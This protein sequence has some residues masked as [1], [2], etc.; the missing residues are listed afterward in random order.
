MDIIQSQVYKNWVY[1]QFES[2]NNDLKTINI[3]INGDTNQP[4]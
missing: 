3:I 4:V 2:D 1:V